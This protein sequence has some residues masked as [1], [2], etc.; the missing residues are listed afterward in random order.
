MDSDPTYRTKECIMSAAEENI[1]LEIVFAD[2]AYSPADTDPESYLEN[3]ADVLNRNVEAMKVDVEALNAFL[4]LLAGC[5]SEYIDTQADAAEYLAEPRRQMLDW[6]SVSAALDEGQRILVGVQQ[7]LSETLA[8]MGVEDHD[9]IR[10]YSDEA[11]FL[12]LLV[13]HPHQAEI[14]AILNS[15]ECAELRQL[16]QAATSGMSMAGGLVGHFSVPEEVIE[17][18]E[19]KKKGKA[20]EKM[21]VAE[22]AA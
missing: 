11:G 16:Y 15:P 9:S 5:D 18:A 19:N 22:S 6:D 21:A 4:E 17:Q 14:E 3:E 20:A 7:L 12:H 8:A 1:V 10:V 13:D 2:D